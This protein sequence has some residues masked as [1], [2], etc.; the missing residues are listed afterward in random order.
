MI[1]CMYIISYKEKR[2]YYNLGFFGTLSILSEFDKASLS[3]SHSSLSFHSLAV[4]QVKL[5]F[6]SFL[7]CS[8]LA[9]DFEVSDHY[10]FFGCYHLLQER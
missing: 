10:L 2:Q 6:Y 9:A 7:L 3:F 1:C 8:R 5:P 4:L